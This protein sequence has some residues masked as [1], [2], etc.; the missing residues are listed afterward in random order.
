MKKDEEVPINCDF[1]ELQREINEEIINQMR[2]RY[3]R[4]KTLVEMDVW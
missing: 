2:E 1:E 3:K 4:K